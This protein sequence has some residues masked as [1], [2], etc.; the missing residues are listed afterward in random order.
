MNWGNGLPDE[1]RRIIV[2]HLSP[3]LLGCKPGALFT[4]PAA[5]CAVLA[6]LL[7]RRLSLTA[8]RYGENG[9]LVFV[10]DGEELEKTIASAAAGA[11]LAGLGYPAGAPVLSVV[12]HLK[13]RFAGGA[14][15]H[16]IGLFLGYPVD[17]VLG[18][19]EHKGRN[20]K[21]C[22]YW[23]VYGDVER[24]KLC[25][26]RYDMCSRRLRAVMRS[27]VKDGDLSAVSRRVSPSIW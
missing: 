5:G 16:E 8:L 24:A 17:D 15:P 9:T 20:Y 6:D 22:G 19:V 26:R 14:F 27:A 13:K 23:K 4:V 11:V 10:F 1:L 3:V 21:L 25:F 7:P 12:A 18:F 2:R